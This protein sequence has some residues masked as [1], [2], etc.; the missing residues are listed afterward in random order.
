MSKVW[1]NIVLTQENVVLKKPRQLMSALFNVDRSISWEENF[2]TC[3]IA[4][5][6][7]IGVIDLAGRDLEL[8]VSG[9]RLN[10]FI[11]SNMFGFVSDLAGIILNF[12]KLESI[13]A[14]FMMPHA[15]PSEVSLIVNRLLLIYLGR[16][17]I[18]F[19]MHY[20]HRGL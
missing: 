5:V 12:L 20:I 6:K 15:A 18:I 10:A 7:R 19:Y 14:T 3:L 9:V 8:T 11:E 1:L 4:N 17:S 13:T 2:H 16:I